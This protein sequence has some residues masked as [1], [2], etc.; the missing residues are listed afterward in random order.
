V[1]KAP[2]LGLALC[3]NASIA[4]AG[5]GPPQVQP[6]PSDPPS[7]EVLDRARALLEELAEKDEATLR[8]VAGQLREVAPDQAVFDRL[9]A[10][11]RIRVPDLLALAVEGAHAS[12]SNAGAFVEGSEPVVAIDQALMMEVRDIGQRVAGR[13]AMDYGGPHAVLDDGSFPWLAVSASDAALVWLLA[14]EACHHAEHHTGTRAKDLPTARQRELDADACAFRLADKA[15]YSLELLRYV[16]VDFAELEAVRQRQGLVP[17]EEL[18]AHP[19]FRTRLQGLETALAAP[20]AARTPYVVYSG[21]LL[22]SDGLPRYSMYWFSAKRGR[23]DAF[24][25]T[26]DGVALAGAERTGV[27]VTLHLMAEATSLRIVDAHAHRTRV[28]IGDLDVPAFRTPL[29]FAD[30][31]FASLSGTFEFDIVATQIRAASELA[32]DAAAEIADVIQRTGAALQQSWLRLSKR[33]IDARQYAELT[34]RWRAWQ[35]QNLTR[36]LGP[37]KFAEYER[38]TL[39][40]VAKVTETAKRVAEKSGSQ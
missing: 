40:E 1:S 23:H 6:T 27:G 12:D 39:A 31:V 15:G 11:R 18:R 36:I 26:G 14:H 20:V 38:A 2:S 33:E 7:S 9:L 10:E 28:L 17:A 4:A 25:I 35:S 24:V 8:L 37:A 29:T 13:V 19:Y 3:L 21:F 22:A 5:C 32:P 34:G 30:P 16:L